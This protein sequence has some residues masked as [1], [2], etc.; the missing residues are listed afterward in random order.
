[1]GGRCWM[2][3]LVGIS[4]R[5]FG[6]WTRQR[7]PSTLRDQKCILRRHTRRANFA[8]EPRWKPQGCSA[9][10]V[11]H[12]FSGSE[13]VDLIKSCSSHHVGCKCQVICCSCQLEERSEFYAR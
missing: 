3:S 8:V 11:R 2:W 1:M 10:G 6:T 5:T 7:P 12:E 13:H 9:R 4:S